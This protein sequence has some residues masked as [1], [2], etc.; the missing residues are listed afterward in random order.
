MPVCAA[1]PLGARLQLDGLDVSHLCC[2]LPSNFLS[3]CVWLHVAEARREW[4]G[5]PRDWREEGLARCPTV[6]V[7]VKALE[8]NTEGCPISPSSHR[9]YLIRDAVADPPACK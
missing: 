3:M 1:Q 6:T 4:P 7:T 2:C 8:G 9:L 5:Y